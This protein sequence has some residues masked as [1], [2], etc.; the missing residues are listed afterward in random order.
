MSKKKPR[1]PVTAPP[2]LLAASLLSF[3]LIQEIGRIVKERP[4]L[5]GEYLAQAFGVTAVAVAVL[6][7]DPDLRSTAALDDLAKYMKAQG[8][9]TLKSIKKH[10][11]DN[12]PHPNGFLS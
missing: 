7:A 10:G 9:A 2:E 12:P 6:F 3:D 8:R 5:Q 4:A 1:C 11:I